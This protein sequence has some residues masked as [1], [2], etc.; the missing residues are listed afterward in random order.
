MVDPKQISFSLE[1]ESKALF[2][3]NG[4]EVMASDTGIAHDDR[5]IL[6]STDMPSIT[7]TLSLSSRLP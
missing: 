4:E 2:A 6:L 5:K 1:S 3:I 7:H